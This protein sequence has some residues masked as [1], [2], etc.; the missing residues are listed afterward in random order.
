M[1][2]VLNGK[3]NSSTIQR[4]IKIFNVVWTLLYLLI[5]YKNDDIFCKLQICLST[6]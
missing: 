5:K 1:S 2:I 6:F 4:K 3:E